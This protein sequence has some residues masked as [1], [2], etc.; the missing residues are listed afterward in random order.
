MVLEN[1]TKD[2]PAYHEE[3]FGPVFSLFRFY[4]DIEAVD[5]A[6][7]IQ[8]GLSASVFSKDIQ[9][10]KKKAMKIDVGNVFINDIVVTDPS[11]PGGPTKDSGYGREC[12]KDGM[13]ETVNRKAI[14]IAK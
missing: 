2:Q 9:R 12:Y 8:Y 6:N 14:T 13:H 11:I 5:I 7:G 4:E 1:I 10:A 3:L